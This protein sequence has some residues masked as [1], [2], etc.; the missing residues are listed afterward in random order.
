MSQ[1]QR[2]TTREKERERERR[3]DH[4]LYTF[5]VR[6]FLSVRR[7]N[8]INKNHRTAPALAPTSFAFGGGTKPIS[9]LMFNKYDVDKSGSYSTW[10]NVK[11]D[12]N[13]H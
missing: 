1:E 2:T 6:C 5:V 4:I 3:V 12:L 13:F 8:G 7:M 9:E 10:I 11:F